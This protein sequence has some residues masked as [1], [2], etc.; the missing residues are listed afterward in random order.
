M[1]NK[2]GV[3]ELRNIVNQTI[4]EGELLYNKY[5]QLSELFI[6]TKKGLPNPLPIYELDN[7]LLETKLNFE[8]FIRDNGK[9]FT[10]LTNAYN[11]FIA[12]EGEKLQSITNK[13]N[14][15]LVIIN[16]YKNIKNSTDDQVGD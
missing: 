16:N 7:N 1:Q 15:K 8:N 12:V 6:Q 5:N 4:V 2:V 13:M 3:K 9:D 10:K 11:Y 14:E